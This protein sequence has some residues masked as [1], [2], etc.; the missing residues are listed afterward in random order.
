MGMRRKI[1]AAAIVGTVMVGLTSCSV[2]AGYG[3]RLN[4]DG[5]V[6]FVECLISSASSFD[7]SVDYLLTAGLA[8]GQPIEWEVVAD[9]PSVTQED[10]WVALYGTAPR[11]YTTVTLLDPPDG[12]LY[13]EFAGHRAYRGDLTESEWQ[14]H[15]TARTFWGQQQP[16]EG[17]DLENLEG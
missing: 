10:Y 13:V 5:T 15:D 11:G 1:A 3:V 9:D 12:W 4:S 8:E 14:W 7:F 6:D 2:P 17:I 16:C